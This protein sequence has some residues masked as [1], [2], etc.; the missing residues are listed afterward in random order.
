[1]KKPEENK[2]LLTASITK[3]TKLNQSTSHKN[4]LYSSIKP[5]PQ[6]ELK[7]KHI[8]PQNPQFNP[9]KFS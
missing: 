7:Y 9:N 4:D 6:F 3:S 1:M 5:S 2:R 8:Y